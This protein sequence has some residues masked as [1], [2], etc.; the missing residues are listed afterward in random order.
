VTRNPTRGLLTTEGRRQRQ[1]AKA[2][3][4]FTEVL[5]EVTA[6]GNRTPWRVREFAEANLNTDPRPRT[7]E[8]DAG[9]SN[10]K[11]PSGCRTLWVAGTASK[12]WEGYRKGQPGRYPN[13]AGGLYS[14]LEEGRLT[15]GIE[16][17]SGSSNSPLASGAKH[18][19]SESSQRGN[20]EEGHVEV[21]WSSVSTAVQEDCFAR[22]WPVDGHGESRNGL[23]GSNAGGGFVKGATRR[24]ERVSLQT[25]G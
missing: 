19:T 17:L 12:A 16:Q 14:K 11:A 8:M 25:F 21:G 1:E 3:S 22:E 23:R 24:R 2:T 4:R 5:P 7:S 9:E 10:A 18:E 13:L 15:E 20:P 6:R